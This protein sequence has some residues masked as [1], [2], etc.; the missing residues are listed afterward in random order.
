MDFSS[1]GKSDLRST[2]LCSLLVMVLPFLPLEDTPCDL[3]QPIRNLTPDPPEGPQKN[4]QTKQCSLHLWHG[5]EIREQDDREQYQQRSHDNAQKEAQDLPPHRYFGLRRGKITAATLGA[6]LRD[7]GIR[8]Q[9]GAELHVVAPA[10]V[11]A[12]QWLAD[13][14]V[15]ALVAVLH[16]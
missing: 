3:L 5:H 8:V 13:R 6:H 10:A 4:G 16:G 2:S 1:P 11:V 9:P 7:A 15:P 12:E 14:H